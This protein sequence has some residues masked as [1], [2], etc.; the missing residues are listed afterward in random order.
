MRVPTLRIAHCLHPVDRYYHTRGHY[1]GH[2]A[3]AGKKSA[4]WIEALGVPAI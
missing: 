4:W 1:P 3:V 2:A